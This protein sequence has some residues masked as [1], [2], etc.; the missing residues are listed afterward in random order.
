MPTSQVNGNDIDAGEFAAGIR[1]T[2]FLIGEPFRVDRELRRV[3]CAGS[4][5]LVDR[6]IA[7]LRYGGIRSSK[8]TGRPISRAAN[9]RT[10]SGCDGSARQDRMTLNASG[11]SGSA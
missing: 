10:R 6:A 5:T 2:G 8:G 1:R 9:L 3:T 7:F 11:A 4:A